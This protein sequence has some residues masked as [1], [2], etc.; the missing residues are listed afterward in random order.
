MIGFVVIGD[1]A[2]NLEEVEG[3]RY[4]GRTKKV[5]AELIEQIKA[6]GKPRARISSVTAI[7]SGTFITAPNRWEAKMAKDLRS[8]ALLPQECFVEKNDGQG[9]RSIEQQ[10]T[11][12]QVAESTRRPWRS[13][14]STSSSMHVGR[15]ANDTSDE[16]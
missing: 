11:P 16:G 6:S 1:A 5:A 9:H 12:D 2:V 8:E 10:D 7:G 13:L 4:A 3:L 14:R 15:P